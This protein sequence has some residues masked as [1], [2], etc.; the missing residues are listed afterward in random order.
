MALKISRS[1]GSS[2]SSDFRID[3][4][5]LTSTGETWSCYTVKED[6][7]LIEEC[8]LTR[9]TKR[10]STMFGQWHGFPTRTST[11]V[12]LLS[13]SLFTS[14]LDC[15]W[16]DD[17]IRCSVPVSASSSFDIKFTNSVS[18]S[19]IWISKY[20]WR[21]ISL[22]YTCATAKASLFLVGLV[23]VHFETWSM[24]IIEWQ[25]SLTSERNT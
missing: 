10:T 24:Q 17:V 19:F 3:K 13:K 7:R 14:L 4:L 15:G 16:Y 22:Y 8:L 21:Q 18:W 23:C 12:F 2:L 20:P 11:G 5:F 1:K 6:K 9:G 25:K